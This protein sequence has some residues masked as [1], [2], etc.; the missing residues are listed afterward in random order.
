MKIITFWC[1]L[2]Q[3]IC[4]I[5]LHGTS[6]FE[7]YKL[8]CKLFYIFTKFLFPVSERELDYYHQKVNIEVPL[9]DAEQLKT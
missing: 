1:A 7:N 3:D 2:N 5:Q 9:E 8:I 4:G 6:W